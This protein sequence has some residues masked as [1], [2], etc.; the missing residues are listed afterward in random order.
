M[1]QVSPIKNIL[2]RGRP[3]TA[4][5][6]EQAVR[7]TR[8]G[9]TALRLKTAVTRPQAKDTGRHTAGRRVGEILP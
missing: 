5:S 1:T 8:R 7:G 4:K 6:G 9:L 2:S 3:E